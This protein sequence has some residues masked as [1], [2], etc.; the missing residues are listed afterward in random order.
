MAGMRVDVSFYSS[1][2]LLPPVVRVKNKS[3]TEGRLYQGHRNWDH[4]RRGEDGLTDSDFTLA[5]G[6]VKFNLADKSFKKR[7]INGPSRIGTHARMIILVRNSRISC[8]TL[9]HNTESSSTLVK[10]K[11]N[12]ESK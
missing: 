4:K 5:C 9:S 10:G 7:S 8:E 3:K 6:G 1:Y 12:L 2:G 11:E